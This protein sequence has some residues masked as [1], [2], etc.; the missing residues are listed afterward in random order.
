MLTTLTPEDIDH[1]ARKRANAKLG[2]YTHAVVY[3]LV[4]AV[5]V[6]IMHRIEKKVAIPGLIVAGGA[7]GG[8]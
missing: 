7:A 1:L 5:V 2:W 8:H 4:N 3:V 6:F